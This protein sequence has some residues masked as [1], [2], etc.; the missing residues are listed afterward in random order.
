MIFYLLNVGQGSSYTFQQDINLF[1]LY[2]WFQVISMGQCKYTYYDTFIRWSTWSYPSFQ[3]SLVIYLYLKCLSVKGEYIDFILLW[4][5]LNH[6]TQSYTSMYSVYNWYDSLHLFCAIL[7][8]MSI[9]SPNLYNYIFF[10]VVSISF[11][12]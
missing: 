12:S 3:T 4:Q 11:F 8:R 10:K 2:I 5:I 9:C 1:I 6:I 7:T